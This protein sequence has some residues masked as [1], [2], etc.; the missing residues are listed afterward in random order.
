MVVTMSTHPV[1]GDEFLLE[2]HLATAFTL[3]PQV[4]GGIPRV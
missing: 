4:V 1:V 3:V 2:N